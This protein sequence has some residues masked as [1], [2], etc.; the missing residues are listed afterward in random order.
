MCQRGTFL[1]NIGI[2]INQAKDPKTGE[3]VLGT[4]EDKV[5]EAD[6]SGPAAMYV[7]TFRPR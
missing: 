6:I 5:R 2:G 1:V 7:L 3:R 4:V